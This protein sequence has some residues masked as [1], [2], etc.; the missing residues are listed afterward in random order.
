MELKDNR[1]AA[2]NK[3]FYE[4]GGVT[5]QK[6]QCELASASPAASAV[7]PAF[8]KPPERCVQCEEVSPYRTVKI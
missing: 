8:I 4:S 5:P 1:R 7:A 6:K 2:Y 3:R